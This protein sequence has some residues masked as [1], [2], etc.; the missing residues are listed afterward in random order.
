MRSSLRLA[1]VSNLV[2][3]NRQHT[4]DHLGTQCHLAQ[5]PGRNAHLLN[6]TDSEGAQEHANSSRLAPH[7]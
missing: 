2:L 6:D 1:Q 4:T 5:V 7:A 3:W